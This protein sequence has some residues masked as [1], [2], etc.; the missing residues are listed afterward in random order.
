VP[1]RKRLPAPDRQ[2]H[3]RC[4]VAK[5]DRLACIVLHHGLANI[6]AQF[7]MDGRALK[8]GD[9]ESRLAALQSHDFIARRRE[10]LGDD[11][12]DHA[13]ADDNDIDFFETLHHGGLP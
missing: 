13:D 8:L 4:L 5:R 10:F 3:L 6:E 11:T 2:R 9:G 12:A 7:V 1:G